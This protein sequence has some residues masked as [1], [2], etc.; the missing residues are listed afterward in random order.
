MD[1]SQKVDLRKLLNRYQ[2]KEIN[3]HQFRILQGVLTQNFSELE[4]MRKLRK[5]KN[6]EIKQLRSG[7]QDITKKATSKVKEGIKKK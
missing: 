4:Y 1:E 3:M 7:M 2:D 6:S 5:A